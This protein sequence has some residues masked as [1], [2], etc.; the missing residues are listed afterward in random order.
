[1]TDAAPTRPSRVR[2][3]ATAD[4]HF[5]RYSPGGYQKLFAEVATLADVLL[6]VGDLTDY[7]LPDEAKALARELAQAVK[8]PIVAV[9]GN[10]DHESGQAGE[11]TEILR[12]AGVIV[13][14]GDS[15]EI[16]GVGFAGVKGFC[17]GFG[18]HALGAW[19]EPIIK[20]YVQEGLGEVLKLET[21]LA[22]LRTPTKI[23]LVHYAI[24]KD[25]VAGEPEEIYPFLGSSRFE[26]PVNRFA[27]S[28]VFHGHAHRGQPEGRTSAG[29]PVYNVAYP[30]LHRL[31]P[32][33]P[34]KIVDVA[35]A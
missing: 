6:I 35:G 9:L 16:L 33:Q 13:L 5:G 18:P 34:F 26:E 23:A 4:L 27:V 21:A 30:L 19:G 7:G 28:A 12:E 15:C 8:I 20:S 10:H 22:R 11:I 25:T 1:M 17:G 31:A 24:V 3:A 32:A 29:V 14:D 2:L